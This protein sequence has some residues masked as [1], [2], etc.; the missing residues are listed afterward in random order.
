MTG[1]KTRT[2]TEASAIAAL[3][4]GITLAASGAYLPAAVA[5]VIG[6]ALLAVYEHLNVSALRL[7][8]E[9]IRDFSEFAGEEIEEQAEELAEERNSSE[10]Q[11]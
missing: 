10:E 2:T 1:T 8:K 5:G 9:Q 4:V 7:D 6:I 11:Q 3:S